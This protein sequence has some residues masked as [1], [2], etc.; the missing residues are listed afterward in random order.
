MELWPCAA[1]RG[2]YGQRQRGALAACIACPPLRCL[3]QPQRGSVACAGHHGRRCGG[4][5]RAPAVAGSSQTAR[6]EHQDPRHGQ[7]PHA[8]LD[9][10]PS[11][12]FARY[13]PAHAVPRT[14]AGCSCEGQSG[15]R[16][17]QGEGAK[18]ESKNTSAH[19]EDTACRACGPSASARRGM[20]AHACGNDSPS[21]RPHLAPLGREENM[22][23]RCGVHGPRAGSL[24]G[25]VSEG[26][27]LPQQGRCLRGAAAACPRRGDVSEGQLL[28]PQ[29]GRCLRGAAA[30]PAPPPSSPRGLWQRSAVHG[31]NSSEFVRR[32]SGSIMRWQCAPWHRCR[33]S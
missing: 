27:Q 23:R 12:A 30:A 18:R 10:P 5:R 33:A 19:R 2:A 15:Q 17:G 28:L 1:A 29:Q 21:A 31:F 32:I 14:P 16:P 6:G 25:D 4:P 13:H 22:I 11:A 8:P 20:C 26:Q 7:A 3:A 24:R 9:T